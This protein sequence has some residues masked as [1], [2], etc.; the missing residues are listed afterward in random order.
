M[1]LNNQK[2]LNNKRFKEETFCI[3][4]RF[5]DKNKFIYW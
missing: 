3:V 4:F 5:Y 2:I 1:I